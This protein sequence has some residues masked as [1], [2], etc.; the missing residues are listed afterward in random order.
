M[1]KMTTIQ[2]RLGVKKKS[3]LRMNS[4][5]RAVVNP[6][7]RH[8]LTSHYQKG[9]YIWKKLMN[10]SEHGTI[11]KLIIQ[12]QYQIKNLN[13]SKQSIRDE[14]QPPAIENPFDANH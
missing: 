5:S 9:G 6:S 2:K 3:Q 7:I 13:S 14:R 4:T 1:Q 8:M 10:A 11:L 12:K